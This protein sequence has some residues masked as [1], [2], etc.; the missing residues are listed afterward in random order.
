MGSGRG[1]PPVRSTTY[2]KD[3]LVQL[4]EISTHKDGRYA[5][6]TLRG[7]L[8][9]AG[10]SGLRDRLRTTCDQNGGRVVLDLTDLTFID[11]TGLAI[12]VEY[13]EKARAAG[14]RL[15]LLAPRAAV[16]RILDITGLDERLTICDRIEEIPDDAAD[17]DVD[18]TRPSARAEE[19]EV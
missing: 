7:E 16:L 3:V 1:T 4:L 12:L 10:A 17:R 8:D 19:A 5:V 11:S 18:A 14:G 2:G 9:L 6:V 15:I 13:H